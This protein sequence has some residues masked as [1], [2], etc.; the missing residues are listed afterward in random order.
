MKL[1]GMFSD[2]ITRSDHLDDDRIQLRA[3]RHDQ[4]IMTMEAFGRNAG[5]Y[6]RRRRY[7][8]GTQR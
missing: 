7:D 5:T 1:R 2:W 3:W 8:V 4:R 6:V